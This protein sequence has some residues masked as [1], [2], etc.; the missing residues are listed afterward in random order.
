MASVMHLLRHR[1]RLVE[2]LQGASV[3][4]AQDVPADVGG[5]LATMEVGYVL[6]TNWSCTANSPQL[7]GYC[8]FT[9]G[10]D[11]EA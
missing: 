7:D 4:D 3:V 2:E 10:T 5:F 6:S 1:V 8:H 11:I 9:R